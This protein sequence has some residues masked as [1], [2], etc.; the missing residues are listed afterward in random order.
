MSLWP[1]TSTAIAWSSRIN[2]PASIN[3]SPS[4]GSY[5]ASK[6]T[7]PTILSTRGSMISSPSFRASISIP[8]IVPQSF[9]VIVQSWATSTS[10]LVKYPA[11]AVLRAVSARPLRAPWV[12]MKYSRTDKPS[13]KFEVIGFSI[14]SPLLPVIDF[15]GFAIKPRIPANCLIWSWLPLAPESA[16]I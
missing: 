12:E 2:S 11:S 5:T 9:S 14:I 8:S 6:A 3:F 16:I 10:L 1:A 7:L 13:R 15:F 4:I